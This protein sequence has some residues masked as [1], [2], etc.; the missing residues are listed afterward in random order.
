MLA[1]ELFLGESAV[2]HSDICAVSQFLF[3]SFSVKK[4]VILNS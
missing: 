2:L 3:L 4:I 1:E